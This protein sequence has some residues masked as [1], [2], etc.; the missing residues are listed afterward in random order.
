MKPPSYISVKMKVFD[1]WYHDA[2]MWSV[3][4]RKL[5]QYVVVHIICLP[6][7]QQCI[8]QSHSPLTLQTRHL[9]F[10]VFCY[11]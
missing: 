8:Q 5:L 6:A 11:V 2:P 1:I 3:E 7:M 4:F 10:V 9:M